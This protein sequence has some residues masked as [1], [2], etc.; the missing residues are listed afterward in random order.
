[1]TKMTY[2]YACLPEWRFVK[3]VC[4]RQQDRR[5]RGGMGAERET[6]AGAREAANAGG[7]LV[8]MHHAWPDRSWL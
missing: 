7:L 5:L 4:K 8:P 6:T 3:H 2:Q 1:M